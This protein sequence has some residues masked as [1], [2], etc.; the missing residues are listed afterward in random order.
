MPGKTKVMLVG[1]SFAWGMS[2]NPVYNSYA[3]FLLAKGYC[4][5][6]L[7]IIG[8]DPA[9]YEAVVKKYTPILQPDVINSQL[10]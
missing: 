6:N 4:V 5:Y 2:A 1:D 10:F 8:T 3:D 7:G 9:Q